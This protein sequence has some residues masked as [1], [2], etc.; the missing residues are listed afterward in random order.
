MVTLIGCDDFLE[1]CKR[2]MLRVE[3]WVASRIGANARW[4]LCG[5]WEGLNA[6]WRMFEPAIGHNHAREV[7]STA[8]RLTG[9]RGEGRDLTRNLLRGYIDRAAGPPDATVADFPPRLSM[10]LHALAYRA[11]SSWS[12]A[13]RA[14]TR[15]T[16]LRSPP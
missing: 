5:T 11:T 3:P 6:V 7:L 8:L 4:N 14:S 15:W 16:S 9:F 13:A 2:D 1:I 12:H 10:A